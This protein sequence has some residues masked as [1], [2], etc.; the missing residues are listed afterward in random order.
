MW[1]ARAAGLAAPGTNWPQRPGHA[2]RGEAAASATRRC[3]KL[4]RAG[5]T[6]CGRPARRPAGVRPADR[7]GRELRLH[8][9]TMPAP[10]ASEVLM[11]RYYWAAKAVTQLN[12]ILLLNIEERIN[13]SEAAPMRPSTP[14]PRQGAACSR[15]PATTC[16]SANPHAILETFLLYQQ[17]PW[18]QGP[19]GAHAAR[20]VQRARR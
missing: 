8:P 18:H 15:W 11:R 7:R 13:G 9:P 2:V 12:Q 14:L 16:T 1:V 20:A 17:T 3:C 5:C 19:V 10:G 4:I 6:C